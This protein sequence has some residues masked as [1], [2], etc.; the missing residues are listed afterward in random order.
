ML[1]ARYHFVTKMRMTAVR[2]DV[3]STIVSPETWPAWWRWLKRVDVIEAGDERGVGA[4]YRYHFG[5]ALPYRLRFEVTFARVEPPFLLVGDATGELSGA[6]VWQLTGL[7]EGGT[8]VTY[9]WLVETTRRWMNVVAPVARP[10]FSWNHD[11]LMRDFGRGLADATNSDL[12]SVENH[13]VKPSDSKF[14]QPPV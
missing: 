1:V 3:W 2:E 7:P 8:D 9:T 13:T 11:V 4:R 12:L 5:T 14:Y 6:G 10:A